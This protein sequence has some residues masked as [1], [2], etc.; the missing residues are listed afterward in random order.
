MKNFITIENGNVYINDKE[1]I[2]YGGEFQYFRIPQIYWESSLKL[3]KEAKLNMIAFYIPWIWHEYEKGKFDFSGITMPERDLVYFLK[4]CKKYEFNIMVRP[5]PYIYAEYQGFGIPEWL[6]EKHPEILILY[7]NNQTNEI[8]LNHPVFLKYVKRWF[9]AIIVI[10]KPYIDDKTIFAWQLDN[11]TG[12]PQFGL[13]PYMTDFNPDTVGR[14]IK[15]LETKFFNIDNL[16]K[17]LKT[18][19]NDF[20][21]VELPIKSINDKIHKRIYGEFIEDYIVEYLSILKEMV[22]DL[23]INIFFYLNDP[24]LCQWPNNSLKKAKIAPIGFDNYP[25]FTT[26]NATQDIPFSLSYAPE[27]YK[28][29]N[30][31]NFLIGA[32]IASGW[33]DPRVYVS[34]ESTMQISM[35]SLIRGMK[36]LSYYLLHD[37][38]EE[39]GSEW[40]F[41]SPIDINGNPTPRYEAIKKIGEFVEKYSELLSQSKEVYSP[42]GL[43]VYIPN[44]LDMIRPNFNLVDAVDI[45]NKVFLHFSGPASIMGALIESSYNPQI[46]DI[47]NITEK[48]LRKLK[49]IFFCST[50]F[51]DEE[52]YKKLLKFVHNGGTLVTIGYPII[53]DKFGEKFENHLYPAKQYNS[54]NI[55]NF[56]NNNIITQ[57]AIDLVG[58]QVV[59]TKIKHKNSLHTI[60]MMQPATESIKYIGKWGTWIDTEKGHKLWGNKMVSTW[61]SGKGINTILRYDN[62][63]VGY[64]VR[65]GNG[66]SIFLGTFLGL[67]YDT[68]SFYTKN[69]QKKES[70][71]NFI[72]SLLTEAGVKPLHNK[73]ANIEVVKRELEKGFIIFFI[74]RGKSTNFKIETTHEYCENLD[75]IFKAKK[76]HLDIEYSKKYNLFKGW[77]DEDDILGVHIH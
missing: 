77:L 50:G 36:I 14:Y 13:V 55:I 75:I 11:E 22:I 46:F 32:E 61:K 53:E 27:F 71:V 66:K 29:I 7:E 41:Q 74:N 63:T 45:I 26:D 28:S 20:S 16:N 44:T 3:L 56:G 6:R 62:A 8:A 48:E 58:Y 73:I 15:Y 10:L 42:I 24:Y 5:G 33:F 49:V 4:L 19:Y 1:Y 47:Q 69:P 76:S 35:I 25:K 30:K 2:L 52:S 64:S 60:D 51:M 17:I 67:F 37:G 31:D 34:P 18:E 39:D 70:L 57:L 23:G 59:R 9:E 21:E 68:S 72:S 40:I 65:Y 38:L 12:L 54:S 43:G